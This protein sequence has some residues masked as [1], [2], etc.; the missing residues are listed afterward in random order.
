M[1][2]RVNLYFYFYS[3]SQSH[4]LASTPIFVMALRTACTA[5]DNCLF[6]G[7]RATHRRRRR[8]RRCAR[9]KYNVKTANAT[10]NKIKKKR[11]RMGAQQARRLHADA[12]RGKGEAREPQQ[13]INE[14]YINAIQIDLVHTWD[15]PQ[16]RPNECRRTAPHITFI[17]SFIPT[18]RRRAAAAPHTLLRIS[19]TLHRLYVICRFY[20]QLLYFHL[21]FSPHILKQNRDNVPFDGIFLSYLL[22]LSLAKWATVRFAV[23]CMCRLCNV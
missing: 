14:F 18:G 8:Q 3:C 16:L 1:N 11:N 9:A 17:H 22:S 2:L 10:C 23:D 7:R 13:K 19:F 20:F 15:T 6:A 12:D 5:I 21:V 4:S